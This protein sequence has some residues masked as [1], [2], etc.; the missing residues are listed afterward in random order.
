VK[1]YENAWID[2]HNAAVDLLS[3]AD[4]E[5]T[6]RIRAARADASVTVKVYAYPLWRARTDARQSLAITRDDLALM[7]IAL[8]PGENYTVTLR[9]EESVVEQI[10]FLIS[11][12]SGT[13]FVGGAMIAFWIRRTR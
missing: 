4:D 7:R 11:I 6:L 10:G 8:P 2:A 13:F 3:F 9:Y 5:I 1:K 12:L